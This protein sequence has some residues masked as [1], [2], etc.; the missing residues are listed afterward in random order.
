MPK[1]C[2]GI[3]IKLLTIYYKSFGGATMNIGIIIHSQTG[4]TRCVAQKLKEKFSAAGHTVSIE[5]ISAANDGESDLQSPMSAHTMLCSLVRPSVAFR[6]RR[7]CK[8]IWPVSVH[9]SAQRQAAL[10]RISS[11]MPGWAETARF[12]S[13][14]KLY[15]P[16]ARSFMD[17]ASS[18]GRGLHRVMSRSKRWPR[19]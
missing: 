19:S 11:P 7:S 1:T 13:F 14:A 2:S 10:S 18:I 3:W 5:S 4:N 8:H 17:R 6:S 9:F 16:G 15:R 12:S